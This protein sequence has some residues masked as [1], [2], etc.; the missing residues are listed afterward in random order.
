MKECFKCK[1]WKEYS[2]FYKHK[3][4]G[5]GYIGKCK[6]CNKTDVKDNY[7]KKIE[8]PTWVEKERERGREKYKRL[9]Y[10]KNEKIQVEKFPWKAN[11]KY[12]TLS[13]KFN[14]EKGLELH[15]WCYKDEFIEDI[16]VLNRRQHKK[17]HQFMTLDIELR[18][19]YGADGS[20]L[21]TKEKHKQW[22]ELNGIQFE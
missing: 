4:M 2:E 15:H 20:L 6:E 11:S 3:Q 19:F 9:G 18:M 7:Q 10:I 13:R 21:D 1:K 22:L 16:F 5:D 8:N 12:K 17:A 14:I